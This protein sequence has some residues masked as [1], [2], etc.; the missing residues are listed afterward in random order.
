MKIE[1]DKQVV[2]SAILATN[3]LAEAAKFAGFSYQTFSRRAKDLG[4]HDLGSNKG[5]KG[6]PKPW[7]NA[8]KKKLELVDIL[9]NKEFEKSARLKQR[10]FAEG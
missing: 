8:R 9:S 10:L 3:S 1:I 5:L 7:T 6:T 2:E 4:L